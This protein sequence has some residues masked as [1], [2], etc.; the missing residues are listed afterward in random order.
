[1]N[2]E[3]RHDFTPDEIE[4]IETRLYEHNR[5][6]AGRD[7]GEGLGFVAKD[8]TGRMIAAAAGYT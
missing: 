4:D 8:E 5:A 6:A 1:M 2:I 3:P 7:D